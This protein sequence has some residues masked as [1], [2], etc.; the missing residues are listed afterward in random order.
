MITE[1]AIKEVDEESG[2]LLG[3]PPK[4]SGGNSDV[5]LHSGERHSLNAS[6]INREE[7]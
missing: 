6:L 4:K 3:T 7:Y 1:F 2:V 5:S